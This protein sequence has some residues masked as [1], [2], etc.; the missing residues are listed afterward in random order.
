MIV[1]ALTLFAVYLLFY[2]G[3]FN[4][5]PRYAIQILAPLVILAASVLKRPVLIAAVFFTAVLP[6]TQ[7]RSFTDYVQTLAADHRFSVEFARRINPGG[8]MLSTEHQ[9]FLNQGLRGMNA[10]FASE[11]KERLDAELKR[12]M[13]VW[14][15]SG[16]RTNVVD[17]EEWR[18]DRWVKSNYELHLIDALEVAGMRIAFYEILI[19][20]IDREARL[21]PAFERKC[22]RGKAS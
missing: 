22:D 19:K 15:H 7:P 20:V 17:S 21:R 6:Y 2:A 10:V 11:R 18:A 16:A 13:K 14:Y 5:N 3:S 1:Q 4:I 9:V 12:G 8:L